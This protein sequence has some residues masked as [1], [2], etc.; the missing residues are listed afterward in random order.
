MRK[1]LITLLV[2]V[3]LVVAADF[4]AAAAAEY[5]VSKHLRSELELQADPSVRINGFPFVTQAASG[6][7]SEI[8]VAA[9]S[10]TVG[11]L[12]DVWV[13][14]TLSD[15]DAPVSALRSGSLASVEADRVEGRVRVQD[16]DLGRA[17]GIE[18]LRIQPASDD[19]IEELLGADGVAQRRDE[20][21]AV[22][23]VA[24]TDLAGER[25]EVIV[26][27]LLE[28]VEGVVLV[29]PTDVRLST[30]EIGEVSLPS[31]IREPLLAAFDTE[32][33]PGGLPFTAT[34]TAVYV[35]T[36]SVLVEGEAR[37]VT[38]ADASASPR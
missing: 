18:D 3:G 11:P 26:I 31:Q 27:G 15:V 2:L 7:Y 35:E 12:T 5:Q 6:T 20:R 10:V 4:G 28:L 29:T 23:M 14:A 22:R 16:K 13:E 24:T 33:D 9:S 38:F 34:P 36:G 25:T 1:L 32:I 17:I 21:A 19:E 37:D 8:E 30:D